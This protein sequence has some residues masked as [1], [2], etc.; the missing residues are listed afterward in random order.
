VK[1]LYCDIDSTINNHWV[2]IRKWALPSFPGTTI[3]QNAFTR[4][5]IMQDLPLAGALDSIIKLSSEYEIHYLSARN[6]YDSYN[7]T[8]DWLD[9]YNFPYNSI[10]IVAR[11]IDK[12]QFLRHKQCDLLIDDLSKGQEYTDSYYILYEDT[13]KELTSLGIN[14]E[15][16]K[17]N[18]DEILD[19]WIGTRN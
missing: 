2:R 5:E 14:F 19:K 15:I 9:K 4:E 6:F 13:I 10:N 11:S 16:F 17:N 12:V 1:K 18:W 7:I 3:H 8:K